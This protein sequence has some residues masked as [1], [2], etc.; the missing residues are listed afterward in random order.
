VAGASVAAAFERDAPSAEGE[1]A[2]AIATSR[3]GGDAPARCCR[4]RSR[5]DR[6]AQQD[7]GRAGP[8]GRKVQPAAYGQVEIALDRAGH[9]R[10]RDLGPKRLLHRPQ[11]VLVE[12]RL[13]EDQSA[14]IEA[15]PVL[16]MAVEFAEIPEAAARGNQNGRTA[17]DSERMN[18]QRNGEAEGRRPV[19]IGCRHHLMKC[20]ACQAGARKMPI[21]LR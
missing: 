15:Q 8:C 11:R 9:R 20:A 13:R 14:D 16:P 21:D 12:A 19:A 10:G 17:M 18:H 4:A 2:E 1:R 6:R 5:R 3:C 7:E